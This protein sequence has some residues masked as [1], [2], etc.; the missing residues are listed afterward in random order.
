MKADIHKILTIFM[1]FLICTTQH[2]AQTDSTDT[3]RVVL[4]PDYNISI[5]QTIDKAPQRWEHDPV[6]FFDEKEDDEKYLE[7]SGAFMG[8]HKKLGL[9]M[10]ISIKGNA[11]DHYGELGPYTSVVINLEN[12]RSIILRV[13]YY[14]CIYDP[15]QHKTLYKVAFNI[16][17]EYR[18]MLQ[19]HKVASVGINWIIGKEVYQVFKRD[20]LIEQLNNV[21]R[22]R[23]DGVIE[24]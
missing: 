9:R 23:T 2:I 7:G 17:N 6:S 11:F 16:D 13:Y 3:N 24:R 12:K 1:L 10:T 18:R 14:E 4:H 20:A 21:K 19:K 5:G 8:T 22:A 15:D